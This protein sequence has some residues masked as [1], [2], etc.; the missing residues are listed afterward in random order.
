VLKWEKQRDSKVI[1]SQHKKKLCQCVAKLLNEEKHK[2]KNNKQ[3][4]SKEEK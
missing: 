4:A 1:C 2:R 3:Q